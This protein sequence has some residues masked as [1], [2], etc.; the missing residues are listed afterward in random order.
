MSDGYCSSLVHY[1]V[2]R[3][4]GATHNLPVMYRRCVP[5]A[6]YAIQIMITMSNYKIILEEL[7]LPEIECSRFNDL[8]TLINDFTKALF[9]EILQHNS[10]Y[11]YTWEENPE[12]PDSNDH[13]IFV[14]ARCPSCAGKD[15]ESKPVS[16]MFRA[17]V[18]SETTL[19]TCCAMA[20]HK[21]ERCLRA[22]TRNDRCPF[23]SCTLFNGQYV[24]GHVGDVQTAY[25]NTDTFRQLLFNELSP[26]THKHPDPI[27]PI[28]EFLIYLERSRQEEAYLFAINPLNF[29]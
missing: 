14:M 9:K 16:N 24:E 3:A 22:Y 6:Q 21:T 4:T 5:L 13:D 28:K 10:A 29:N 18:Y 23:C 15:I 2:D 20:V 26:F 7:H 27:I 11:R 19:T 8:T 25:E 12:H 17:H 1:L